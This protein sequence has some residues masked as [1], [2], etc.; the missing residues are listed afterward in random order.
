M[1]SEGLIKIQ[2]LKLK[3]CSCKEKEIVGFINSKSF[4]NSCFE[5][6]KN[7]IKSKINFERKND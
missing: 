4:C 3:C 2:K 7:K 1:K 6:L 5:N